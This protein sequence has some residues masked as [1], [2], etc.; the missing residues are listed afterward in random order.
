[1]VDDG[2][3]HVQRVG[4]QALAGQRLQRERGD[5]DGVGQRRQVVVVGELLDADELEAGAGAQERREDRRRLPGEGL[6][7]DLQD[8]HV[9]AGELRRAT[10]VVG[11]GLP[12]A[13]PAR[14]GRGDRRGGRLGRGLRGGL[15]GRG[16]GGRRRGGGGGLRGRTLG[17]RGFWGGGLG[18]HGLRGGRLLGGRLFR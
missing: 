7:R 1:V 2:H 8:P 18:G 12:A 9:L 10:E 6:L 4:Q 15:R 17:A 14:C 16:R 13:A 11:A 3:G 5:E